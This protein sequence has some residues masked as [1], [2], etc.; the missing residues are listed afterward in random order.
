MGIRLGQLLITATIA[1]L[2]SH[3]LC[4]RSAEPT[5]GP[6]V[7]ASLA[8]DEI[9]LALFPHAETEGNIVLSSF[10][11]NPAYSSVTEIAAK[12]PRRWHNSVE[13]LIA[14]RPS[15][16]FL[17]SYNHPSFKIRLEQAKIPFIELKS[18]EHLNDLKSHVTRIGKAVSRDQEAQKIVD[19][20]EK[21]LD[22]IGT[23]NKKNARR[24]SVLSYSSTS[25]PGGKNTLINDIIEHAGGENLAGKVGLQGWAK[26]NA[27]ILAGM[28]PDY[29]L[30]S[31][32]QMTKQE[33]INQIKNDL[34]WK[35][36][37]AVKQQRFIF[38]NQA[39]L[40]SVSHHVIDAVIAIHRQLAEQLHAK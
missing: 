4:A 20:F 38:V 39:K 9:L 36:L 5:K 8:S 13:D 22:Q 16:V 10:V 14:L 33:A 24:P 18:F 27:E 7:S 29:I 23:I 32:G 1:L 26:L 34:A 12:I 25:T 6:I 40:N 37:P 2:W 30:L 21:S 19:G 3:N 31:E 15:I 35:H 17:A 28:N 11:D